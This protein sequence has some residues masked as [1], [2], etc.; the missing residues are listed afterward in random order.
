MENRYSTL[1]P[2]QKD[3]IFESMSDG[4]MTVNSAG[5]ITYINSACTKIF[6]IDNAE[7]AV[8]QSFHEYFL[9][10][11]KNRAF[12][13]L[14][15]DSLN[16]NHQPEK[17]IVR[18]RTDEGIKHLNIGINL[19]QTQDTEL[20]EESPFPGMIILIEDMSDKFALRQHER[21][22]AFIFA[23]LVIC[24]SIYLSVWSLL[25]FTLHMYLKS[26]TYTFIIECMT[27]AIFLEIV[28]LTSFSMSDI[29]LVPKLS[30]LKR[31]IKETF[32]IG[33]ISCAILLL[34][35][36]I[37][38]L[39]GIHIKSYYIGGSLHG[40]YVY[41]FTAFV[42]EFLARGVMQTCVKSI[43]RVKYQKASSIILSS[44]LFSLM[45]M[46]FGFYFMLSAFL[47][48]VGLGCIYERQKNIWGCVILHW[49]CGYLAM[50]L[51][52]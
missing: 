47:L 12:N 9:N 34:S 5:I 3:M 30:T 35:K 41:I 31:D 52:F 36:V 1:T 46:P 40:A 25:R 27:F 22:C 29:G 51:Y 21:D 33:V 14:F 17:T 45:H 6:K 11:R 13:K 50:C 4:I 10:N 43:M 39:C 28:F 44:L 49:A 19:I 42:Q 38:G 23:G 8:G 26:S 7:E 2:V 16:K 15:N 24:I 18:Y 32:I 20:D 37:L 48:S